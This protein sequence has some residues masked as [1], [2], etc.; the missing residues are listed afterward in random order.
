MVER[1]DPEQKEVNHSEFE[2]VHQEDPEGYDQEVTQQ[3][4]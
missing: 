1:S 3:I 4:R 2:V